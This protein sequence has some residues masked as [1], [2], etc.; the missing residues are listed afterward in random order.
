MYELDTQYQLTNSTTT[1]LTDITRQRIYGPA[2]WSTESSGNISLPAGVYEVHWMMSVQAFDAN[3]SDY[4]RFEWR[5]SDATV[6]SQSYCWVP[7]N[8]S[9]R[10][11][12]TGCTTFETD[13][14]YTWGLYPHDPSGGTKV[15]R[16][17]PGE[18]AQIII[19]KL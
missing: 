15:S 6:F 13:G 17:D 8:V 2:N 7:D 12:N 10:V 9:A 18:E 4:Q 11:S 19:K 16:I 5:R 14:V 3:H 1:R